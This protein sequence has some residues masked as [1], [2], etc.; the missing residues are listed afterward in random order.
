MPR[1]TEKYLFVCGAWKWE[2]IY[3]A[4]KSKTTLDGALDNNALQ[5]SLWG[6]KAQDLD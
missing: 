5:N 3:Q 2:G 4:M 6:K 1:D